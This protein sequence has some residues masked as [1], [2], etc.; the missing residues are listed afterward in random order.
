MWGESK[1]FIPNSIKDNIG[2]NKKKKVKL[3]ILFRLKIYKQIEMDKK[4]P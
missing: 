2:I 3:D 1:I 4:K